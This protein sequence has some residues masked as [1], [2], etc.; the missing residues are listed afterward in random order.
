VAAVRRGWQDALANE[1]ETLELV[2]DYCAQAHLRTNRA[3]QRWMLRAM[4]RAMDDPDGAG[5][6]AW[7]SLSAQVYAGVA[8]ALHD[9]G[10]IDGVPEFAAFCR[11]PSQRRDPR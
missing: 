5:A 3:H 8:E 11:P 6:D 1:P 2:M 10:L 4:E 9:Q 7:G